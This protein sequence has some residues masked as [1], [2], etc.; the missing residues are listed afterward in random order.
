[1]YFFKRLP[2]Y[3]RISFLIVFTMTIQNAV[4][5]NAKGK[6]Q[7]DEQIHEIRKPMGNKSL[8]TLNLNQATGLMAIFGKPMAFNGI[9]ILLMPIRGNHGGA[10]I[11][12]SGDI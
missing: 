1:M 8:M 6:I 7:Y 3:I 5:R 10:E 4:A 11:R 2:S 9:V 12:W